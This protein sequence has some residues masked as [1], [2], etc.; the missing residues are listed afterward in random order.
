MTMF[1]CRIIYNDN[2]TSLPTLLLN[3]GERVIDITR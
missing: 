3:V 1:M 2:N